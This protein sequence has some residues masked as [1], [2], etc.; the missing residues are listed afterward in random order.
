MNGWNPSVLQRAVDTCTNDSGRVE[1]CPVLTLQ[2]QITCARSPTVNEAVT[3]VF[4]KLPGNNPI[5]AGPGRASTK[6]E[7]S[8]PAMFPKCVLSFSLLSVL[9]KLKSY[10][11]R[12]LSTSWHEDAQWKRCLHWRCE[13][14]VFLLPERRHFPTLDEKV[15]FGQ[16]R[17]DGA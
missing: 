14:Q 16:G 4:K 13:L 10:R 2:D 8:P 3:G 9:I 7:T 12:W 1:D 11:F 17:H 6:P 5:Q 15:S